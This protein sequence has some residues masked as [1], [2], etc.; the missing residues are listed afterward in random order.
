MSM[1]SLE[2][3]ILKEAKEV[4]GNPKLRQK[5]ILEWSTGTHVKAEADDE[6]V[7]HLPVLKVFICVKESK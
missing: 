1:R 5:D 4:T 6:K 2:A 3:E 7:Y